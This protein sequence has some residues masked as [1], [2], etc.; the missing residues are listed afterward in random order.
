MYYATFVTQ[1]LRGNFTLGEEFEVIF[2]H[3]LLTAFRLIKQKTKMVLCLRSW[4]KHYTVCIA[5]FYLK[6]CSKRNTDFW[7]QIHSNRKLRVTFQNIGACRGLIYNHAQLM[8]W[9]FKLCLVLIVRL[10][11]DF[12]P[13][14]T[15][16]MN[17]WFK[18][19]Q[20]KDEKYTDYYIWASC[21]PNNNT[22]PNKRVMLFLNWVFK[23]NFLFVSNREGLQMLM[24]DTCLILHPFISEFIKNI[25]Y[26]L[27][28]FKW[29]KANFN[30][31][32]YW[33]NRFILYILYI[34]IN[35]YSI[36]VYKIMI[37]ECQ[38]GTNVDVWP[39]QKG[40]LLPS[41]GERQA[42]PEP[43]ECWRQTGTRGVLN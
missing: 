38:R 11:M 28:L 39:Y 1:M 37:D 40:V 23:K 8:W 15:G 42:R 21:D 41:V 36:A 27:Q 31:F 12:I 30:S 35:T 13:N 7:E 29:L 34:I 16:K 10:I 24:L 2:S 6:S 4:G 17:A 5:I 9:N 19:S 43:Q 3:L 18:K 14:H 32:A 26:P 22:Y 20:M 33:N 25:C